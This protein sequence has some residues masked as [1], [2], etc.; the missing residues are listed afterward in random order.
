M[1]S[2]AC[3][4]FVLARVMC[5]ASC[6]ITDNKINK[7]NRLKKFADKL[8]HIIQAK[9]EGKLEIDSSTCFKSMELK[10]F[11][12]PSKAL[13]LLKRASHFPNI[14][15]HTPNLNTVGWLAG[16]QTLAGV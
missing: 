2:I 3:F 5:C 4:L 11:Y 15:M 16:N 12:S 10:F 14:G 6:T 9:R 13:S 7:E 1:H 8:S